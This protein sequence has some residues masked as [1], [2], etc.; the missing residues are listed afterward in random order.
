MSDSAPM[1][2]T[3]APVARS[4]DAGRSVEWFKTGWELFLK[5][6]GIWITIAVI[7]LV[8]LFVLSMIP[9]IG[10]IAV[11]LALPIAGGGLVLGCK[12]LSEGGEL[13]VEHLFEGFQRHGGSLA[14]VGVLYAVG[15]ML[16]FGAAFLIGGSG[17]IGG[18]LTQG[19]SGAGLAAGSVALGLLVWFCLSVLLGMAY[20]FAPAL[21][22]LHGMAPVDAMKTSIGACLQNFLAF[23]IFGILAMVAGFVA[24]LP[25]GLGLIVLGPVMVGAAYASYLDVFA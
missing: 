17:A 20:W 8:A 19:W 24:M 3:V 15:G 9:V 13:R 23:F 12:S 25:M 1:S 7:M 22:V 6:P 4:V 21:V 11:L 16:A 2:S 14:V 10:Q 5:N 18:A